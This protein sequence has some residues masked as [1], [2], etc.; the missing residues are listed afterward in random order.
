MMGSF[1]SES[2]SSQQAYDYQDLRPNIYGAYFTNTVL[3]YLAVGLR[4]YARKRS[5]AGFGWDDFLII[6]SLVRRIWCRM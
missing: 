2:I 1:L 3:A 4:L 5:A 6:S